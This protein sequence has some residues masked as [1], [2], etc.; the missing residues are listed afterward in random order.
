[1]PGSEDKTIKLDVQLTD[2]SSMA[3]NEK[4]T[5]LSCETCKDEIGQL[6]IYNSEDYTLLEVLEGTKGI[7]R[8][9][10]QHVIL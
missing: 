1:M 10:G 5:V 7:D 3:V 2:L 9:I 6:F 8:V 4:L